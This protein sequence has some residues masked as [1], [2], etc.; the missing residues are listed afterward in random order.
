MK[1][2]SIIVPCYNEEKMIELFYL[3]ATKITNEIKGYSFEYILIN[4]GSKDNT[5]ET[6]RSLSKKHED[7][8]YF[9]FSR[10]FGKEAAIL[11]GLRNSDGDYAIIMDADLQHPP[12]LIK[13]MLEKVEEG[14]DSVS[15]K[16]IDRCG[17]S[18]FRSF[19]SSLFFK[20]LNKISDIPIV[21]GATDF[22][23]MSRQMVDSVLELSEYHRFSKG[24]FEWV[25]YDTY[26]LEYISEDRALGETKWSYLSLFKYAIE[27]IVSFST[28]P[29]RLSSIIGG[30]ISALS[31]LYFV[32]TFLQTLIFGKDLP[33][34]ASTICLITFL[35]GIQ[36]V[37]L[38][39]IG[40]YLAR[41]Y[42]QVKGRPNY[43]IKETN[44]KI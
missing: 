34:Y 19:F 17:E 4:D 22:R 11:A 12:R 44:K 10:N 28:T 14:Y 7:I 33:G 21:E 5:I 27:G 30:I 26:W 38:G 2:I 42:I 43:I 9:S 32:V 39:I 20:F 25:G 6:I 40:E 37:A 16:R 15:T 31:F 24:I 35:G 41:T 8:K 29:L 13:D 18:K 36:L 23:I 3:E 1:K